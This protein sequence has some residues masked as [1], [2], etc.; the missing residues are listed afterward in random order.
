MTVPTL[1]T[2]RLV[3]RAPV[4]KDARQL[5]KALNNIEISKWLTIVPFPYGISDAEW[6]IRENLRG[7]FGARHVWL[8]K[9]LVGCVGLDEELGYWF[10]EDVWGQ[11][12]A[13]EAAHAVLTHHFANPDAPDVRS[14]H[15]TENHGSRRVLEKLGFQDVGG[16]VH[17][18]NAR[19]ADVPG[20]SMLLT[21]D[22]WN[23]LQDG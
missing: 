3:L 11:G 8:G 10:V 21:R 17:F 4:L 19:Q 5:A 15:F 2:D 23:A 7:K 22:R 12:I 16:H 9:R 14:S 18:S 20:R 1:R 13:T 6:F